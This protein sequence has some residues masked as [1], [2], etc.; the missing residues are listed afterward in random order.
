[1][2]KCSTDSNQAAPCAPSPTAAAC[3]GSFKASEVS[4][5]ALSPP[6]MVSVSNPVADCDGAGKTLLSIPSFRSCRANS[7]VDEWKRRRRTASSNST[8]YH[9]LLDDEIDDSDSN[10]DVMSVTEDN[11]DLVAPDLPSPPYPVDQY[12]F[13][14]TGKTCEVVEEITSIL[15][16]CDIEY[17][18]KALKCKF[19]CVKYVHYSH[20]EFVVRL[21]T[22]NNGLLVEFQRRAG[23]LLLWDGLYSVM[24]NKLARFVD[25]SAPSCPQSG[26]QKKVANRDDGVSAQL[27][28]TLTTATQTPTSGVEA[29]KIMITSNYIDVQREGCSGLAVLTQDPENAFMVAQYEMVEPLIEAAESDDLDM[30]RS[31]VGALTNIS[32]A[33]PSFPS[34]LAEI[35][36]PQMKRAAILIVQVL[37]KAATTEN[38]FSLELMRECARALCTFGTLC[39]TE[40]RDN[41]ANKHLS[42]HMNHRDQQ[43]ATLCRQALDALQVEI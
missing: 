27:W 11:S 24:Y 21:Y 26:G 18:F 16:E 23:S 33:L 41:D 25:A 42:Q 17:S 28:R 36:L 4:V 37:A 6:L 13:Y 14:C 15:D 39:P 29:M 9:S 1:M 32:K 8:S 40:V 19:K 35:T 30:A 12:H 31:S 34:D 43:F 5:A 7:A 10:D 20:V 3:D 2:A 22:T 38:L